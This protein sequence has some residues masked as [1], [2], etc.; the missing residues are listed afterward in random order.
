M[1]ITL[2]PR[3]AAIIQDRL[4]SGRYANVDEIIKEAMLLLEA[5]EHFE[6]LRASLIEEEEDI[7]NGRGF[8][9]APEL[10]QQTWE[11]AM[12]MARQGVPLDPDDCP[13]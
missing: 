13:R 8:E 5:Q 12:E 10:R 2:S 1:T 3:T 11:K 7:Q 4:D 6:C 9:W